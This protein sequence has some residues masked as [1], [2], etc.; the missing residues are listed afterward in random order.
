MLD[1]F[2]A[3][4]IL[5]GSIILI[6]FSSNIAVKHS[7]ALASSLGVSSLIIGIT[8]VSIGTDVSEIFNSIISCAMG[9]GDI[10]VGDS[11]GSDLTQLTLVFGLLPIICGNFIV[12]RKEFLIIGS[13]EILSLILIFTVVEKGYF[14]RLDALFMMLSFLFYTMVT[15]NV[16]KSDMLTKVDLMIHEDHHQSIG[17]RIHFL[18]FALIGFAGVT[19]SSYFIVQS[20]IFLSSKLNIHEFILS[21]FLLSIGTSLPELSV[22]V[23]ALRQKEYNLAIG[24]IIG[25]CIVDSTISIAIGQFLFP[26]AVSAQL[27]I[28][29]VLYTI[30]A[31]LIVIIVV[32]KRQIMDKK[33]G[34]LFILIYLLAF[35]LLLTTFLYHSA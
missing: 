16:T 31:S 11:V 1:I 8:L 26:Q 22:D 28:P 6:I 21:F 14:T 32:S 18:V 33:A 13:C 34:I 23:T 2:I 15:Y 29:T 12:K 24:D 10:D 3:F 17:E 19:L 35:P 5:I 25:S 27:A 30:F 20:I 9:H 4:I 7:A